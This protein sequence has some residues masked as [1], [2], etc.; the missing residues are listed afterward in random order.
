MVHD[1][2]GTQLGGTLRILD[3]AMSLEVL[4]ALSDFY[5]L[6]G[7]AHEDNA[8]VLVGAGQGCNC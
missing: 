3:P 5:K 7:A 4:V 1:R 8:E 2:V 6:Q